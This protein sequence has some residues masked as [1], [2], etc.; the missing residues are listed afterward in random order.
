MQAKVEAYASEIASRAFPRSHLEIDDRW[1]SK[2]GDLQ[3]DPIKFPDAPGMVQRLHALGFT[4][5][6]WVVPFA[7]PSADAYAEGVAGGYWLRN[8]SSDGANHGRPL[9]ITWW[10]G[11]GVAL[12]VSDEAALAWFERRLRGLMDSTGVDGF[13]FD[14]GEA[15]FVPDGVMADPNEYC[16]QWVRFAARFGGGGEVRCASRTQA[17][18]IWT[19]EFDKDSR[20]GLQNG[21]RALVTAALQLG[22]LGYPFALPDMV[23][24]N[25]VSRWRLHDL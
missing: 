11:E 2:Y 15:M 10:Q 6:A 17:A 7:E 4:V 20:W 12:N 5:T 19:R 9:P 14:A 24:G 21:L 1:S 13:K 18:G 16:R 3:F 8:T 22:V 23:G 25:A